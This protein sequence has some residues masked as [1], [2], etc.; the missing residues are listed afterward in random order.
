MGGPE[1][2]CYINVLGLGTIALVPHRDDGKPE[3]CF[4]GN[5]LSWDDQT[6]QAFSVLLSKYSS[7]STG[8]METG[9]DV[10]TEEA[11]GARRHPG[12]RG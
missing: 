7:A 5:W 6:I 1:A 4:P 2:Q 8:S 9:P 12:F 10:R 3:G 11:S